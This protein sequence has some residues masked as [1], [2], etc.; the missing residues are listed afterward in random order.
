[1]RK[2]Y[3]ILLLDITGTGKLWGLGVH[4]KKMLKWALKGVRGVHQINILALD[5]Y[6]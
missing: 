6:I 5:F 1:M 2:A 4:T 3:K